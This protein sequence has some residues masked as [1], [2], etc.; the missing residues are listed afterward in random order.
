MTFLK[1]VLEGMISELKICKSKT[2]LSRSFVSGG[3]PY[4]GIKNSELRSL[5]K[6]GYRLERPP[7]CSEDLYVNLYYFLHTFIR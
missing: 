6:T 5:L 7:S 4:P 1:Q 3:T 2:D